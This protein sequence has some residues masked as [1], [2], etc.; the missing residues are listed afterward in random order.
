MPTPAHVQRNSRLV[1][2]EVDLQLDKLCANSRNVASPEKP[3]G[4]LAILSNRYRKLFEREE[5]RQGMRPANTFVGFPDSINVAAKKLRAAPGYDAKKAR[6]AVTYPGQGN[7]FIPLAETLTSLPSPNPHSDAD[8]SRRMSSRERRPGK[9][10]APRKRSV[11]TLTAG[12][13]V[14]L[15][16]HFWGLNR[17][18]TA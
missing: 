6:L 9:R 13:P 16:A 14:V 11:A 15:L 3:S 18:G 17:G 2:F 4:A 12:A 5:L 1:L 7:R 8:P 10:A